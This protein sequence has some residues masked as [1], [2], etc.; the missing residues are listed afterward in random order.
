MDPM[1]LGQPDQ[2]LLKGALPLA[3]AF[4]S[5][6][7]SPRETL[8]NMYIKF[9]RRFVEDKKDGDDTESTRESK[10]CAVPAVKGGA[11]RLEIL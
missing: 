2:A 3:V 11:E 8:V 10:S 9:C 6:S 1:L 4:P 5:A 7:V